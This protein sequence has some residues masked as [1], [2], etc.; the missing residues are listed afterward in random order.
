MVMKKSK[1]YF[2]LLSLLII[3]CKCTTKESTQK[4]GEVITEKSTVEVIDVLKKPTISEEDFVSS[5]SNLKY[6][7]LK[8]DANSLIAEMTKV[9]E[10]EN[11][12]YILDRKYAAIRIFDLSGN[13]IRN[14]S[15]IGSGPGQ[16]L[17]LNGFDID[18]EKREIIVYTSESMKLIRYKM[19]GEFLSEK[20][21][22]FFGFDYLLD[23]KTDNNIFFINNN[24]VLDKQNYNLLYTD[25]NNS[26][27]DNFFA[28]SKGD[29]YIIN[30]CGGMTKGADGL[31]YNNPLNDTI[32]NCNG[33]CKA[34]YAVNF[35]S[36]KCPDE[37]KR[38]ISKVQELLNYSYLENKIYESKQ[39]IIFP[40]TCNRYTY[41]AY[42]DKKNREV[43]TNLNMPN[44]SF[45][46]M[47][48]PIGLNIKT[49]T[50]YSYISKEFVDIALNRDSKILEKLRVK[51]KDFVRLLEN[52]KD[53]DNPILIS[54]SF[55]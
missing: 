35:G 42:Y 24:P 9:I 51:N 7:P 33:S 55:K 50:F 14:L 37:V 21:T 25:Y 30:E 53:D 13:F 27:K 1:I 22:T 29:C 40:Y 41:T 11:N 49:N 4:S 52:L 46:I 6:I 39:A 38:S 12:F 18:T 32:F 34:K 10:F 47:R 43:I 8:V 23:E 19:D 44:L 20:K 16:Y 5:V 26:I 36:L 45:F 31:V 2:C 17:S 3:C 48:P 15:N 54:Y 28:F